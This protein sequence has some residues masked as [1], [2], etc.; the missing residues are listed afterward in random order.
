MN[1]NL[2]K[3]I[4]RCAWLATLALV[5][6]APASQ[7]TNLSVA[8]YFRYQEVHAIPNNLAQFSNQWVNVEKQM[9]VDKV[10]LETT[11]NSRRSPR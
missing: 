5:P 6:V 8:V 11:R 9:K 10:Y 3:S 1:S 2:E 4:V 7:Y